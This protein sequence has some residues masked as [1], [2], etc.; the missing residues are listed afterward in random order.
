MQFKGL[1]SKDYVNI[2][3]TRTSHSNNNVGVASKLLNSV[4]VNLK[5]IG[6]N[7]NNNN[8]INNSNTL[9]PINNLSNYFNNI[10]NNLINNNK[11]DKNNDNLEKE[12]NIHNM[13]NEGEELFDPNEFKRSFWIQYF[14]LS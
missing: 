12:P 2:V 7:L 13:V 9:Q 14:L 1:C 5:D 8:L 11:N 6:V 10:K 4:N 3:S